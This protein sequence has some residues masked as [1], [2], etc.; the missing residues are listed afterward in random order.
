MTTQELT[1]KQRE[2]YNLFLQATTGKN[3]K[4][5]ADRYFNRYK[6]ISYSIIETL[7]AKGLLINVNPNI[8]AYERR[9]Y[10][11]VIFPD[12]QDNQNQ[13]FTHKNK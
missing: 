10:R 2:A 11:A 8:N 9:L 5:V 1:Q 6:P 4:Y 3:E 7:I 13:I 12:T